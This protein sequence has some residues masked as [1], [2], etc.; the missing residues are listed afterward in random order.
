[1]ARTRR[2]RGFPWL[3]VAAGV[4]VAGGA[5][6]WYHAQPQR[7]AVVTR[8]LP[9]QGAP[10]PIPADRIDAA[11]EGRSV[12]VSGKVRVLKPAL[13]AQLG[14]SA[15]APLLLR[16]VEMRQWRE[17]CKVEICSYALEW[18]QQPIDS[19]AFKNLQG[20][21]NPAALPFVSERFAAADVR[22]GAFK[23]AAAF[24]VDG[25]EPVAY[26]VRA[27][28]LPPNLAATF[29]E[30]D[31]VLYAGSDAQTASA[32]DL[33]VSYRVVPAAAVTLRGVQRGDR[34]QAPAVR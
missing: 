1:M 34:L 21:E 9:S 14:I 16:T 12:I 33:R 29:R 4:A 22:L 24:A 17:S 31:G 23:L 15:D 32:G 2:R 18:S 25:T 11:N 27:A 26:P 7:T 19:R 8:P 30:R 28:Q 20:H 13:D 3:T 5:A 10:S 6:W